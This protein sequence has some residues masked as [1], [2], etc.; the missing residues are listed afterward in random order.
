MEGNN[1]ICKS[2]QMFGVCENSNVNRTKGNQYWVFGQS[3][4]SREHQHHIL[5]ELHLNYF[6]IDF[7]MAFFKTFLF[8]IFSLHILSFLLNLVSHHVNYFYSVVSIN[9]FITVFC[10]ASLKLAA[11]VKTPISHHHFPKDSQISPKK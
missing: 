11:L 8:F 5:Q 10:V 9:P 6:V 3:V 1:S 7:L 2:P 4:V